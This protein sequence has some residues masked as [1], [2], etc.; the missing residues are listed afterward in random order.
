[1]INNYNL[2]TGRRYVKDIFAPERFYNVPE[3]QRPYVWGDDQIN[4][5]LDDL[6]SAMEND[7]S[8]EYFLGCMIWNTKNVNSNSV[9]Y[10]YQDILDGQQRFIT[11]FLLHGVI[12]DLSEDKRLKKKVIDRLRQ[13][14]DVYDNVPERNRIVFE[15]RDDKDFLEKYLL[16]DGGTNN[17]NDLL[18]ISQSK[19]SI[20]IR[21][22]SL[23]ILSIRKWWKNIDKNTKDTDEF[24]KYIKQFFQY[25]S[26]KVLVLYLATPDNL[27]DAYNLFTVLNSRGLQLQ[28]SDILR[29]Q[30]LREI[31]DDSERKK[32]AEKWSN[33]EDS[34]GEPFNGFDDFL[35]SL[36]FIKMKYRSDDNQNL[37]KAFD[38]MWKRNLLEK[39]I[40]TLE[41]VGRFI[42]HYETI[43]N[44]S[45]TSKETGSLFSNLNTILSNVFGNQYM[46]PLMFYRDCFG[47]Y[48]IIDFIIKLDNLLTVPWLIGKRT[49][50]TRMF[51]LLRK[52]NEFKSKN[53]DAR[54]IQAS[55][56]RFLSSEYLKYDYDD[57]KASTVL[58]INELTNFLNN[59]NLGSYAGVR[60]N[61]IRY[62]LLKLDLLH[63]NFNTNIQ[64]NKNNSSIE[65]LIPR[66]IENTEWDLNFE[67]HIKWLHK[68]GNLVLIDRRKNSSLSNRIYSEKKIRYQ[69][70]IETRANTNFV[71]MNN[72]SWGI[73]EVEKNHN[74]VVHILK[75][76]Y[77]GNSLETL[78]NIKNNIQKYN[79]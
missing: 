61:K 27:D 64:F 14:E 74:R 3:Y 72:T 55:A 62:L 4:I 25:L 41:F 45:I 20:S 34:I 57:E 30:N 40:P 17:E 69:G 48:K 16:L 37:T 50:Q 23:A 71:F 10:T 53:L 76:Y 39:G 68:L 66:K 44:G 24:Q 19:S 46:T 59:E 78:I 15:I 6:S 60:V 73:E 54:S 31:S 58:D 32:Y 47:D 35:W 21:N 42:N 52:M 33:F 8:K 38:F 63:G 13:E 1:M 2:D 70:A 65:H 26:S 22:M 29:A 79:K 9:N 67:N 75:D 5:L 36:V 43:T 77:Q 12:R 7:H 18:N 51:I 49:S 28:V 56:D 11:L